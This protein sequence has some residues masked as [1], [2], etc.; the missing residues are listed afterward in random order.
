M[1]SSADAVFTKL[2]KCLNPPTAPSSLNPTGDIGDNPQDA[3][4]SLKEAALKQK[5]AARALLKA[6]LSLFVFTQGP[7]TGKY[8]ALSPNRRK[9]GSGLFSSQFDG[10]KPIQ[11]RKGLIGCQ[12]E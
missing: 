6:N 4:K 12:R 2:P 7:I 11:E 3:A 9:K 10:A 1:H 5:E 8:Q